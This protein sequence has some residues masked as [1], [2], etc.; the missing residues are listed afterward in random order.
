MREILFRAIS[1]CKGEH[2]LYGYIRHY[3]RNSHTQK[4]TIFDPA[5]GI[6][7]DIEEMTIGQFTGLTDKN[8]RKVFDGDILRVKEYRN[9]S[10]DLSKSPNE[11]IEM[12]HTFALEDLKGEL[13]KEYI[14]AVAIEEGAYCL[15]SNADYNDMFLSCLF[16]NMNGSYPIFDFEVIGNI[17]DNPNLSNHVVFHKT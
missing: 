7:T 13:E 5:T 1:M 8:G 6:E 14:S 17:Q 4:W 11:Q 10:S 3:A 12:I 16:G 9:L 2:W 15:S